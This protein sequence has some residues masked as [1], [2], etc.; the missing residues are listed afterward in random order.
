LF[1]FVE[2]GTVEVELHGGDDRE[3][4]ERGTGSGELQTE[5]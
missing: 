5:R 3:E 2:G 1:D 4:G